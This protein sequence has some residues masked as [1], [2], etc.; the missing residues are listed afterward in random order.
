MLDA[1]RIRVAKIKRTRRQIIDALKMYGTDPMSF[2]EICTVFPAVQTG[3]LEYDMDA[4]VKE[5]YVQ[6]VNERPNMRPED[7]EYELTA[8]GIKIA[9]RINVDPDLE[10]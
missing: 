8:E 3:H 4:L 1:E 9:D 2:R 5:G 10:P 6:V 7:R